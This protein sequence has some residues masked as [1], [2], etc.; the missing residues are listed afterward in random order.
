MAEYLSCVGET[1]YFISI[2]VDWAS[3]IRLSVPFF[4]Y[5]PCFVLLKKKTVYDKH[6][7]IVKLVKKDM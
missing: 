4:L 3:V 5:S 7:N 1:H 6:I 2:T